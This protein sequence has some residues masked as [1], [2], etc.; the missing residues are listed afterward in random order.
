MIEMALARLGTP[1]NATVMIGDQAETD[2]AAGRAAGLPTILVTTG[3][4]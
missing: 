4:P 2:I 1:R 3:V